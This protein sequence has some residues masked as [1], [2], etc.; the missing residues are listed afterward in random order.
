MQKKLDE[1]SSQID[2]Q[3]TNLKSMMQ[4][5]ALYKDFKDLYKK[6]VPPVSSM[7]D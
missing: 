1:G 6:V 3:V 7:Q 4:T 5:V 2:A